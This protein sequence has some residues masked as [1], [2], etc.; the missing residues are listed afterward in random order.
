MQ[1]IRLGEDLA[2]PIRRSR[3]QADFR[4]LQVFN[5][6]RDLEVFRK[7]LLMGRDGDGQPLSG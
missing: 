4:L 7:E 5:L 6:F 3:R 1:C 2:D